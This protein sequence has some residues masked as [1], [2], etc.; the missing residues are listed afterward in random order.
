MAWCCRDYFGGKKV[1]KGEISFSSPGSYPTNNLR[2]QE[3]LLRGQIACD[4]DDVALALQEL[5]KAKSIARIVSDPTVQADIFALA[6]Y[7][8]LVKNEPG[9]AAKEFDSETRLLQ[10]AKRYPEMAHAT[11]TFCRSVSECGQL[12]SGC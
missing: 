4:K 12:Q 5:Q 7:I 9:M 8:H 2:L 1:L 11:S 10:Q 3:Y 6:G